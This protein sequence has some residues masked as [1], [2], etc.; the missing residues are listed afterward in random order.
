MHSVSYLIAAKKE[1]ERLTEENAALQQGNNS[2]QIEKYDSNLI[3]LRSSFGALFFQKSVKPR[4]SESPLR[5]ATNQNSSKSTPIVHFAHLYYC[6]FVLLLIC[7]SAHLYY[8]MNTL[9]K[10]IIKN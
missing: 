6:T 1:I 8:N 7:I 4:E 2:I 5:H 10:M 9:I 3:D